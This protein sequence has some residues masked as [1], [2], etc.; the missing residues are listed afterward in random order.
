MKIIEERCPI[1]IFEINQLYHI[2]YQR[3][4]LYVEDN[5][6]YYTDDSWKYERRKQNE[7]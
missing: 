2:E 4:K 1:I 6:I 7:I 5:L 3:L